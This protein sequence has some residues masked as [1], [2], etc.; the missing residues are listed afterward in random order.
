MVSNNLKWD[1]SLYVAGSLLTLFITFG[2]KTIS[3]WTKTD[4]TE[5]G[6]LLPA[7]PQVPYVLRGEEAVEEVVLAQD[8]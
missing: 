8:Q 5:F 6:A 7:Q 3:R 1:V 2:D 4:S